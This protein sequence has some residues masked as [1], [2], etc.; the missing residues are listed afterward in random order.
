MFW[1]LVCVE[2][3]LNEK[4]ETHH[5]TARCS[6]PSTSLLIVYIHVPN[7]IIAH[8]A[9]HAGAFASQ[10]PRSLF[11]TSLGPLIENSGRRFDAFYRQPPK[12]PHPGKL[13]YEAMGDM[14]AF[15]VKVCMCVYMCMV[16]RGA[17]IQ[18]IH[19]YNVERSIGADVYNQPHTYIC[20]YTQRRIRAALGF[21]RSAL[22]VDDSPN[23]TALLLSTLQAAAAVNDQEGREEEVASSMWLSL[24]TEP[25]TPPTA[26]TTN[27][28]NNPPS[29]K[30]R[31]MG[32]SPDE[33]R[34]LY[35]PPKPD[36]R[37]WAGMTNATLLQKT[38][39]LFKPSPR[40]RYVGK[41][42]FFHL[43]GVV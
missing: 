42:G 22:E 27:N 14:L 18:Y 9:P 33:V 19:T 26:A 12:N 29:T 4:F 35:R 11:L 17:Y 31:K 24:P 23:S 20:M 36:S 10:Q 30:E 5:H 32:E 16:G 8:Y 7:Q 25:W 6:H 3:C 40:G 15:H 39:K 37:E 1:L 13:G 28:N 43:L 2:I 38:V 41:G 34:W 21:V